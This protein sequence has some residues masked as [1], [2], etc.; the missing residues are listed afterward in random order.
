MHH[1]FQSPDEDSLT[2]KCKGIPLTCGVHDMFQSPDEDSL[3]PK[4]RKEVCHEVAHSLRF[5]PLT[6][7]RLPQRTAVAALLA[8]PLVWFQSPDEDSL[9]PKLDLSKPPPLVV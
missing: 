1:W 6:R 3:T 4:K 8:D 9:T 2:P 7:I 5:S